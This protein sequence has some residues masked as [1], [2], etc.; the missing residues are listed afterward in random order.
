[1][2]RTR[3][4][5]TLSSEDLSRSSLDEISTPFTRISS[6]DRPKKSIR[7]WQNGILKKFNKFSWLKDT[8]LSPNYRSN[9][10]LTSQLPVNSEKCEVPL[11]KLYERGGNISSPRHL[12]HL[13]SRPRH[14]S[15][16]TLSNRPPKDTE[17]VG[18]LPSSL[19]IEKKLMQSDLVEQEEHYTA[20]FKRLRSSN[21]RVPDTDGSYSGIRQNVSIENEPME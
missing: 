1:M 18:C 7:S 3:S 2:L 13:L 20:A 17:T 11:A 4:C 6:S 16:P 15:S 21:S 12:K 10:K 5:Q 9:Y 14:S 19:V 8:S